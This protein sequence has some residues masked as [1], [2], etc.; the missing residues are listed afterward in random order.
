LK[1]KTRFD[2]FFRRKGAYLTQKFGGISSG[3]LGSSGNARV[4]V[5]NYY[6]QS[7]LLIICLFLGGTR[8]LPALNSFLLINS[9]FGG[10]FGSFQPF[11]CCFC[12]FEAR[13]YIPLTLSAKQRILF[14]NAFIPFI[15]DAG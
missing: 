10:S 12:L 13:N 7:T 11:F 1:V 2:L 8:I 6:L 5:K 4:S 15:V 14:C 9:R 3:I